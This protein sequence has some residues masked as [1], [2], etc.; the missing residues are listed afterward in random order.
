MTS[1]VVIN[2]GTFWSGFR[3]TVAWRIQELAMTIF[4]ILMDVQHDKDEGSVH[5]RQRRG[6][7][8]TETKTMHSAPFQGTHMKQNSTTP[9]FDSLRNR[10]SH[11]W[12]SGS[13]DR[14]F[15]T[16]VPSCS[17]RRMSH[18]HGRIGKDTP[19]L[20]DIFTSTPPENLVKT[21]ASFTPP[22][23]LKYPGTISYSSITRSP[24]LSC[25]GSFPRSDPDDSYPDPLYPMFSPRLTSTPVISPSLSG[26][27]PLQSDMSVFLQPVN[28]SPLLSTPQHRDHSPLSPYRRLGK[29]RRL[30]FSS[31]DEEAVYYLITKYLM[32]ADEGH[33]HYWFDAFT[34]VCHLLFISSKNV[35]RN[36]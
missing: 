25:S 28:V 17:N 18:G 4:W 7:T 13:V 6:G 33:C 3:L 20:E 9:F 15:N 31:E 23:A 26:N 22:G 30:L 21:F 11:S 19:S 14:F 5:E 35:Q 2:N 16:T 36:L 10:L 8:G 34:Y 1:F 12:H 29:R 24:V 27:S 32:P